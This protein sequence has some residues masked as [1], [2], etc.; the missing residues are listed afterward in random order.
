MTRVTARFRLL[1]LHCQ[2][3]HLVGEILEIFI[4]WNISAIKGVSLFKNLC[5]RII[6]QLPYLLS[7][8]ASCCVISSLKSSS[9]FSLSFTKY[10]P[11]RPSPGWISK[12][13]WGLAKSI[14]AI[15]VGNKLDRRQAVQFLGTTFREDDGSS[16]IT[17]ITGRDSKDGWLRDSM[18]TLGAVNKIKEPRH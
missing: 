11:A 14:G 1:K 4:S 6:R 16:C 10:F 17:I 18:G 15:R 13:V 12:A 5:K 7:I 2:F 8:R 3:L 9:T